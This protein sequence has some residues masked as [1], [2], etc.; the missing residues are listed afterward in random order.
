MAKKTKRSEELSTRAVISKRFLEVMQ[1]VEKG[2]ADQRSRVDDTMD[3]WDAYNCVL[4]AKQFYNGNSQIFLPI[5]A[6]AVNA[7]VT[8]FTNQIFPQSQRNV[9]VTT[10]NE[11]LPTAKVAL[12]EHHVRRAKLRTQL[13]PPLIKNGD[14]EGQYSIYVGWKTTKRFIV[15]RKPQPLEVDGMEQPDLGEVEDVVE[16]E[17]E[18]GAPDIEIIAD[19]DLVVLPATS[20]SIDDAI[21]DGGS[22]TV[23]RRWTKAKIR[24]LIKDGEILKV[25]GEAL[26]TAMKKVAD[27]GQLKDTGKKLADNAGI[28]RGGGFTLVYET[29]TTLKVDG[30]YRLC[31]GYYGG[32]QQIL[33]IKLCPYWCDRVPVISGP[34][35]KQAG[36]FKGKAPV[37][38]VLDIQIFAND[39]I[40]EGA[41]TA[42]FSAM[43]IIMT[44]PE[45]NPNI[46]SMVLGLASVWAT[47]PKDTQFA[48]FPEL[49]KSAFE[50]V[51]ECKSQIFQSLG[52][53][54]SM[55]PQSTGGRG[56]RNQAEMAIEAQVDI[57]T[58]ADAVTGIE[59]TILTP[60]IERI[61]EYDHQFRDAALTVRMFGEMGRRATMQ[62]VEPIQM[63]RRHE[64]RWYGVEAARNAAQVQQQIGMANVLKEVPPNLYQG[65]RL[66]LAPLMVQLAENTF[67]PRLAPLI[68]VSMKDDMGV[69]PE[70][71]NEMLEHGFELQ[72][73]PGDN[74]PQHM[75]VHM[76]AMQ[77]PAGDAHGTIRAHLMAHQKQMQM[78]AQAQMLAQQG[79]GGPQPPGG[80]GP[81]PGAAP[82]KPHAAKAPAGAIHADRMASAG[83]VGM[84]RKM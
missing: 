51:A 30:D 24:K 79:G 42:H 64:F 17:V 32:E 59:E 56:K 76:M 66:D 41:D 31:R 75:Q 44:D 40:N 45:K 25:E 10:E 53:N 47:S 55:I 36:V 23:I 11:D 13:V 37:T 28:K 7:R 68:L 4:G 60:L 35:E 12:I 6:D 33:G 78:K 49:W 21:A 62:D 65:Y 29:W 14:V 73:H 20:D 50:R 18:E 3:H 52:V 15:Q 48:Q 26:L 34:V 77:G 69:P 8:R 61:L 63:D 83:A 54:P 80:G 72:P 5:I 27:G 67:G 57:L 46:G 84:P 38:R 43:P 71:E 19:A 39:T 82:A 2:V 58:T 74:D 22:V 9:E 70:Q 81:K 1:D 16:E